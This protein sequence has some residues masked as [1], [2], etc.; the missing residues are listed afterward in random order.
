MLV[1]GDLGGAPAAVSVVGSPREAKWR[2]KLLKAAMERL[3]MPV[4]DGIG[5]TNDGG[6]TERSS[7]FALGTASRTTDVFGRSRRTTVRPTILPVLG[8]SSGLPMPNSAR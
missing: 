1:K 7:G 6:I 4:K 5:K 3:Q 2:T 8:S